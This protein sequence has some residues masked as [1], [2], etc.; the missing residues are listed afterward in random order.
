M[1][2]TLLKEQNVGRTAAL[3][4]VTH[5]LVSNAQGKLPRHFNDPRLVRSGSY[6]SGPKF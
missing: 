3:L 1:L 6:T 5:L 4:N 2:D